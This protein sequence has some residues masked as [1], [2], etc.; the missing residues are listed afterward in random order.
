MIT[1][2]P[3]DI[4][5]STAAYADDLVVFVGVDGGRACV[6]SGHRRRFSGRV[7]FLIVR[8]GI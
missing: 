5:G 4:I 6:G 3:K 2:E 8:D 1:A 7:F